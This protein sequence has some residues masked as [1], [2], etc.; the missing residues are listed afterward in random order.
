LILWWAA[1]LFNACLDFSALESSGKAKPSPYGSPRA[2]RDPCGFPT[3][4]GRAERDVRLWREVGS[5]MLGK[6]FSVVAVPL[7]PP[8]GT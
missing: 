5:W 7:K 2:E 8:F 1:S 4:A 3:V 6:P